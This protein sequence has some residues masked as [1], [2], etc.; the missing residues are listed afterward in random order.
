MTG[1]KSESFQ[2]KLLDHIS[3]IWNEKE[4][5]MKVEK[6][7]IFLIIIFFIVIFL[8]LVVT[9]KIKLLG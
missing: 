1:F 5:T 3:H 7:Y 2:G 9:D 4:E 8:L 6:S